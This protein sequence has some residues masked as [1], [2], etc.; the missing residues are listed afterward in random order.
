MRTQQNNG[1]DDKAR[2]QGRSLSRLFTSQ[3]FKRVAVLASLV[4]TLAI[5][6]ASIWLVRLDRQ[7]AERFAG[8]RFAPPVEFYSAPEVLPPGATPP[9]GYFQAVF[10]RRQFRARSFGQPLQAGDQSTWTAEECRSVAPFADEIAPRVAR[11]I[12]FRNS[13]SSLAGTAPEGEAVAAGDPDSESESG[14]QPPLQ[15]SAAEPLQ[16]AAID[17]AGQILATFEGAPPVSSP[18]LRLEPEL[19]AQYYGDKPTLRTVVPLGAVPNDCMNALI[20]VEDAGFWEHS[21]VSLTAMARA[22]WVA[23]RSGHASQGGSTLTQQLV[24]NYFLSDEKTLHRKI[25]EFAMALLVEARQSKQDI[26]ET[27]VNLIYMGQNGPFQVRGWGAASTHYFAQDLPGLDLPQCALLASI[28]NSPG[29]YNPFTKPENALRRRTKALDRMLDLKMISAEQAAAAKAAP[30]P[31]N[32]RRALSEPAPYYVQAVRR[33]LEQLGA[34]ESQGL[35]VYTALNLRA[36]EAAQQAVRS[37]VE[38]LEATL[39]Q[40]KKLRAQGKRLEGALMAADPATGQIQAIVGGRNFRESQFNRAFESHRQ[41]GSVMKPFTF[42]AALEARTEDGKPYG[43]LTPLSDEPFTHR[44]QGQSWSPKNYDGKNFGQVPMYF[45]LKES[46]NAATASLGLTVGLD[47]VVD[48]AKRLGVTSK[49]EP[50]PSITLGAFELFPWE[51]LQAYGTISRFGSQV[52]LTYVVKIET[53][54]GAT[55]YQYAPE[56]EQ[57]VAPEVMAELVGMMKQTVLSG[58]ARGA[59][60]AGFKHPAAGK[61]G[62]TNDKKD[63]WFAGFTPFH[64]A[65][66]W[67]GYDD[68]SP[69]N[70]TGGSGAVPIWTQYM[71]EYGASYPASDFAWPTGSAP[72]QVPSAMLQALG[73]PA[74]RGAEPDSPPSPITL[75]FRQAFTPEGVLPPPPPPPPPAA[76]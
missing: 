18:G 2:G 72:A 34:D 4:L 70:L 61:T 62:T 63:A 31:K 28:V 59:P 6:F 5:I 45:A 27:Y 8:K 50:L 12:A 13:R 1:R 41:V 66:V 16:I 56:A 17:S 75:V 9:A 14:V 54:D 68:N 76:K 52:P 48:I 74:D 40:L 58:S 44:Y 39:P 43:P 38:R 51:V 33:Q 73:V 24:K 37:G 35:R 32:P 3:N 10:S 22:I 25:V 53:L 69:H 7:I 71:K 57:V 15:S 49:I 65:V 36:Q 60:L 21:G 30:L 64:A 42:L 20:A 23:V 29:L 19:F 47:N 55:A 67:L 11:C 26:L 46:L